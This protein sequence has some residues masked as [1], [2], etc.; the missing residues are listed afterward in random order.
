MAGIVEAL[1]LMKLIKQHFGVLEFYQWLATKNKFLARNR[2]RKNSRADIWYPAPNGVA[3]LSDFDENSGFGKIWWP[4]E[5]LGFCEQ[6]TNC[7][8]AS[9]DTTSELRTHKYL[10]ITRILPRDLEAGAKH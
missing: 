4:G 5:F 8:K 9:L 10:I 7:P 2:S 3:R 6:K 1:R